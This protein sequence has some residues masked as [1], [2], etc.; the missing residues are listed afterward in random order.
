VK[1]KEIL[2]RIGFG[3]FAKEYGFV[4][5]RVVLP[6]EGEISFAR[7][8]HPKEQRKEFLQGEIDAIRAFLSE[9]DTAIDIGAHT[10][11]STLPIALAAGVTGCV[12]ALEPN[13]FAY[14]VLTA[15]AG[16]NRG[17][18]NIIPLM[19]AAM[20]EDGIYEF[21]Y[22]DVG[23]CNGGYLRDFSSAKH[24]H[25]VKLKV[26]GRNL[27]NFIK[28]EHPGELKKL[29]YIK[30]DTEG[31]DRYVAQ[32]I[33][34]LLVAYKPYIKSEIYQYLREEE[35]IGYYRDLRDL[36][37]RVHKFNDNKYRSGEE[38]RAEDMSKWEHFDIFAMPDG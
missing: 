34:E 1:L 32:S 6:G 20:P 14:K 25:F 29:R 24:G 7:W 17:K 30:M 35:R 10:G 38:L 13:P 36:G 28:K 11:D 21:E 22:S 31:F 37:Y 2:Y 9:G 16:L 15:N 19:F 33:K 18:T 27:V 3:H 4:V 26:Q 5:E 23:F 8:L 12:F